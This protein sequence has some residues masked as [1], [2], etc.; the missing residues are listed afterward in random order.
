MHFILEKI[1]KTNLNKEILIINLISI[2]EDLR[3]IDVPQ[4][5]Y[6][7]NYLYIYYGLV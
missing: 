2:L 3:K 1:R 6:L 5:K 4:H 7:Y